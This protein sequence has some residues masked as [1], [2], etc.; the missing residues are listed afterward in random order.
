MQRQ[1]T[2]CS[3]EFEREMKFCPECGTQ[4]TKSSSS[5][6]KIETYIT[7]VIVCSNCG[8]EN[9]VNN[10][11]CDGCGVK[12][13]GVKKEKT[14]TVDNKSKP[15]YR[16][17][18]KQVN[19]KKVKSNK[20]KNQSDQ[21]D[22]K[23]KNEFDSKKLLLIISTVGIFVVI[24]L[25]TTGVLDKA[26]VRT[27]NTT[28]NTNSGINLNNLSE[29]NNLEQIV[30]NNPSDLSALLSLA[31]RQQDAGLYEKAIINYKKYLEVNPSDPDARIDLGVCYFSTSDYEN[32][33]KEMEKALEFNPTHQVGLLNLGVV[34]LNAGNLDISK[35]WLRKAIEI[36]PN[37]D[38][39]K[40][41]QDLLNSH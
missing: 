21:K 11:N 2:K 15:P 28:P 19:R 40:R 3:Y 14:I 25:F 24:I 27:N 12:L 5:E 31:N 8:E 18:S 35:E 7:S 6:E 32:A 20:I 29:I 36:N 34:N 16:K 23:G 10:K 30:A 13:H 39:G 41:A 33:I 17:P 1:C 26:E 38:A 4:V 37:S 9:P 22:I